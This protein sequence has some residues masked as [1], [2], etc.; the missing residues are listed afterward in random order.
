MVPSNFSGIDGSPK[1]E[2]KNIAPHD[3]QLYITVVS[4]C[5]RAK[6]IALFTVP[7]EVAWFSFQVQQDLETGSSTHCI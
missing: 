7:G 6:D 5:R 4:C 2:E 1:P 3:E